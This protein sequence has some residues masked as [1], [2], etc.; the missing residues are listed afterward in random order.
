M[1][2]CQL[3]L[4][5]VVGLFRFSFLICFNKISIFMLFHLIPLFDSYTIPQ[6]DKF[7]IYN[8]NNHSNF[9]T[10]K[11][12][13]PQIF[14]HSFINLILSFTEKYLLSYSAQRYNL[15]NHLNIRILLQIRNNHLHIL[16]FHPRYLPNIRPI[17]RSTFFLQLPISPYNLPR[18]TLRI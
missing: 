9:Y 18:P 11:P 8:T 1:T 10:Q 2:K 5:V 16:L 14:I 4:K 17:K 12:V 3:I 6:I 7:F 15:N 13:K